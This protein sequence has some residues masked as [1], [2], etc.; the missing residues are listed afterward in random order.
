MALVSQIKLENYEK[1]N[2]SLSLGIQVDLVRV[3]L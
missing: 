2:N 1:E 3:S